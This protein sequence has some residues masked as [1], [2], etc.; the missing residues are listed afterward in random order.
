MANRSISRKDEI[1]D[2]SLVHVPFDGWSNASLKAALR[3]VRATEDE[4]RQWFPR[5]PLDLALAFHKRGDDTMLEA[6]KET[7]LEGLKFR[8]KISKAVR[9]RIEATGDKEAV[10]RGVTFFAMPPN[11]ATGAAAIWTTCDV[12]WT[13]L[14]DTS[15]DGNWYSKRAILSGVYSS[16]VLYWLGD[17]SMDDADTWDF[18]DRRIEDVMQFEKLKATA[19]NNPLLRPLMAAPNW[20]MSK[21]RAPEDGPRD[22]MPGWTQ[23]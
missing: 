18:L 22:N 2:A 3:D 11:A 13:V 6:L 9:L 7:D 14:G 15:R 20:L 21:I 8:E 10:R 19:N 5:G 12:I 23:S 17:D 4:G 1:L 16:S